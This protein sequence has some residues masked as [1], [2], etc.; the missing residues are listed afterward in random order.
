MTHDDCV[1]LLYAYFAHVKFI[2]VNFSW[3]SES[4]KTPQPN[5]CGVQT[6][7]PAESA[8]MPVTEVAVQNV[9]QKVG[10]LS[11]MQSTMP[12]RT[13]V[14][15]GLMTVLHDAFKYLNFRCEDDSAGKPEYQNRI[16]PITSGMSII[17][18]L[19]LAMLD[20]AEDS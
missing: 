3:G 19:L 8:T 14:P 16:R 20:N 2:S 10:F 11:A 9:H 7:D 18:V 13:I 5:F 1:S 12:L 15:L 4:Y 6:L 17:T